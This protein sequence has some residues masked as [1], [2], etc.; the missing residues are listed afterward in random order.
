MKL[1]KGPSSRN[2]EREQRA[3][4]LRLAIYALLITAS[5]GTAFGRILSVSADHQRHPFLSANDRSR[6]ATVRSLVDHGTFEIDKVIED[7]YWDTIDKVSH[8]GKDG[9][10]HYYSS[11]PPLMAIVLAGE[12]WLIKNTLGVEISERPYYVGRMLLVVTNGLLLLGLFWGTL[13]IAESYAET[14]FAKIAL[15]AIVTFGTFLTTFAVTINNHLLAATCAALAMLCGLRIWVDDRHDAKYFVGAGFFATLCAVNDLPAFSFFGLLG[16]CLLVKF[17]KG[18][19]SWGLPASLFVLA[20]SLGTNYWAHESWRPP[21]M[22]RGDGHV[23]AE[24]P[25]R[26]SIDLDQQRLPEELTATFK[27]NATPLGQDTAVQPRVESSRW[28]IFDRTNQHKYALQK[29]ETAIEVR[30]WD[31]WY[32]YDTSYWKPDVKQGIDLGEPSRAVYAF[33]VLLGHHGI[34]SLS[35]IWLIALGGTGI[36][37]ATPGKPRQIAIFVTLLTVVCIMFY[38]LRPLKDRNYGGMTSGFRWTFWLIPL[39]LVCTIPLL[40]RWHRS[41]W[42]QRLVA[43]LLLFSALSASYSAANPWVH[44]WIYRYLEYIHWIKP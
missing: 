8:R 19:L 12:Y 40:D 5:L 44:P 15:M 35:P 27:Q 17:P 4:Q 20:V 16:L 21:Y 1:N 7:H 14:D 9:N 24:L 39:W 37:L 29:T 10:F 30:A 6:I 11:K 43:M 26:L 36:W 32:D 31:H 13:K 42:G 38:I 41:F 25:R 18:T 34:L 33:H 22:H 2:A 3:K 23:I 28:V